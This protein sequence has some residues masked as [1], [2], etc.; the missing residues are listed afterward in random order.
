MLLSLVTV[1]LTCVPARRVPL[2]IIH[3][4]AAF[5]RSFSGWHTLAYVSW[6]VYCLH[7]NM[8][9]SSSLLSSSLYLTPWPFNSHFSIL[10]RV[11]NC[12]QCHPCF[13]P[14]CQNSIIVTIA[15]YLTLTLSYLFSNV[16]RI[17]RQPQKHLLERFISCLNSCNPDCRL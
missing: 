7:H 8:I 2:R 15:S 13:F 17:C 14:S 6:I 1:I 4:V 5:V 11:L 12:S 9:L 16:N 10:L 3:H